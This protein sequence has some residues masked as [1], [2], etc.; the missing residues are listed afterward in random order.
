MPPEAVCILW[1]RFPNCRHEIGQEL[2]IAFPK[3]FDQLEK[4]EILRLAITGK[5]QFKT[6][7]E[8]ALRKTPK[9][10]IPNPLKTDMKPGL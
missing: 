1:Q 10:H 8:M 5:T 7:V 6:E 2:K 4:T 3:D 9:L